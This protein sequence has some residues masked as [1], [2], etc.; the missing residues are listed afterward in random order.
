MQNSSTSK[1]SATDCVTPATIGY[2]RNLGISAI[3]LF[4]VVLNWQLVQKLTVGLGRERKKKGT[5]CSY[6]AHI[7]PAHRSAHTAEGACSRALRQKV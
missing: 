2:L 6:I 4:G 7:P 5:V 1:S 3:S